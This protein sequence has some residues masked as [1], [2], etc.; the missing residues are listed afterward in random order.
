MENW[1][2][3][4][5]YED[6]EVSNYGRVRSLDRVDSRGRKL[7][8]KELKQSVSKH[9]YKRVCLYKNGKAQSVR[10]HRLVAMAFLPNTN[11]LSCVN[12]KDENKANN[13]L[14]NLEW[15]TYKYNSNYGTVK[16]RISK[17]MKGKQIG[18]KNPRA[19]KVMCINNSII[20]DTVIEAAKYA[21]TY[22]SNI[23]K[24]IQGKIKYA[25]KDPVTGEPLTWQYLD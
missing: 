5:G 11:N 2:N 23:A 1:R 22:R 21:G 7:K 8:G 18:A 16:E 12:H 20:F 4:P 15:C 24:Q 3:I 13:H 10:V 6:Y 9:G 25:G 17:A 14:S 19:R